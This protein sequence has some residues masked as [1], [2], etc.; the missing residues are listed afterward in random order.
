VGAGLR[1]SAVSLHTGEEPAIGGGRGACNVFLTGCNLHC[2]CCQN[3]PI[4]HLDVGVAETPA[5]LAGRILRVVRQTR[6]LN[7]VTGT[8]QV[9]AILEA[10]A[11][12]LGSSPDLRVVWNSSGYERVETLRLLEGLVDVYL[13]DFKFWDPGVAS[14]I[15]GAPDYPEVAREAIREKARQVG[16]LE[17]EGDA[18]RGLIVRHLVLPGCS[19][20]SQ[21]LLRWIRAH[22]SPFIGLSLMSQY[23]PCYK[24]PEELQRPLN[25]EEYRP[26]ADLA[27]E[28][29]FESL[30]LQPEPFR[31][32][33]HLL[34]DFRKKRPFRW[35]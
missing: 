14:E 21:S 23:H 35:K 28:L 4:S 17:G 33:E 18:V 32:D 26:V 34:P 30:F 3:H 29:G 1:V 25:P 12:V 16:P 20:D 19:E 22:L 2:I 8:H 11:A 5:G 27:A 10:L 13:P 6:I 7:L 31:P 9:P 24:A 15:A